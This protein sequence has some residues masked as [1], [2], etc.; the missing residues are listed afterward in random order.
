MS[1][2]TRHTQEVTHIECVEYEQCAEAAFL[3]R[4]FRDDLHRYE[5]YDREGEPDEPA[6]YHYVG[7]AVGIAQEERDDIENPDKIEN[8]IE[9]DAIEVRY[10]I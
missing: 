2:Q 8:T 3:S 1:D 10:H 9:D 6:Y 7:D 4:T 5:R